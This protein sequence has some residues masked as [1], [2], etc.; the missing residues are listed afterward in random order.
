MGIEGWNKSG[1]EA[2]RGGFSACCL[3]FAIDRIDL[4]EA[5]CGDEAGR[6]VRGEVALRILRGLSD[7]GVALNSVC[8]DGGRLV[9]HF[10]GVPHHD[11]ERCASR[12]I[13]GVSEYAIV[14]DW[15]TVFVTVSAG[16]VVSSVADLGRRRMEAWALSA[17]SEAS[18]LGSGRVHVIAAPDGLSSWYGRA[19]EVLGG[20][21]RAL[22]AGRLSLAYQPVVG[23]DGEVFYHECLLRAVDEN[24]AAMGPAE[25]VPVLEQLGMIGWLDHY[26]FGKVVEEL[27]ADERAVLGCNL[28]GQSVSDS[29]W[30]ERVF[31]LL[32]ARPGVARRLVV[33]ITET[34]AIFDLMKAAGHVAQLRG[35]G[36][37]VA[38]DDFGAGFASFAHLRAL[39]VDIVKLDQSFLASAGDAA[40][41]DR[42]AH[43]AGLVRGI[44]CDVVVEGVE[45]E[46]Q[47]A[48]LD[49]AD[50]THVQGYCFGRPSAYRRWR[51]EESGGQNEAAGVR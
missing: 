4:I 33:E 43:L 46:E 3:A 41:F 38:L 28:S 9:V 32:S 47:L 22:D 27:L 44:G 50:V 31:D 16:G 6:D 18:R 1:N 49:L 10:A 34:S 26:V 45:R 24:G 30:M 40:W 21:R 15:G 12:V 8:R 17:L 13:D 2:G 51:Y 7:C 42:V 5:A 25:F 35:L 29:G 39:G 11:V 14:R 19:L 37:R 36:V 23:V 48:V 20:V